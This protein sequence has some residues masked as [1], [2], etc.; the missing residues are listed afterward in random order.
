MDEYGIPYSDKM[1]IVERFKRTSPSKMQV[2]ITM[3]GW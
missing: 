2:S 1:P 3:I